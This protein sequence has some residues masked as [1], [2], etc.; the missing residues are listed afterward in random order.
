MSKAGNYITLGQFLKASGYVQSGGEAKM[1]IAEFNIEV[2]GEKENRRGR[3]LYINDVVV[4]EG[5]KHIIDNAD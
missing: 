2:N 1:R 5:K 4:I 3:K